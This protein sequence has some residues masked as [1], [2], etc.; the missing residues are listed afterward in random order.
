MSN[1]YYA[2]SAIPSQSY[3]T[4]NPAPV[5]VDLQPYAA[6]ST[7]THG[8][9]PV[10]TMPYAVAPPSENLYASTAAHASAGEAPLPM[11]TVTSVEPAPGSGAGA[12]AAADGGEGFVQV[13][14]VAAAPAQTAAPI[15]L[16]VAVPS[17]CVAGSTFQ[18]HPPGRG[19]MTVTVPEGAAA[20]QTIQVAL[21]PADLMAQPLGGAACSD[22][23][24]PPVATSI[25]TSHRLQ[26][27][28]G[29]F[30]IFG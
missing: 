20:G 13:A 8:A 23:A 4:G 29:F 7:S 2:P 18:I 16:Q 21:P 9:A 28:K 10:A 30:G 14:A 3:A 12:A 26:G 19:P 6:S 11:A 17:G 25:G 22:A 27:K 24:P 1:P 5:V 15:V